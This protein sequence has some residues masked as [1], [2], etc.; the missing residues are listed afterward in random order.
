MPYYK[1]HKIVLRTGV[2]YDGQWI[3]EYDIG[4]AN[5]TYPPLKRRKRP[6]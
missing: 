3:C 4:M 6:A 5:G 1:G 2:Q